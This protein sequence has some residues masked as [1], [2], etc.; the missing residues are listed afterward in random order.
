MTRWGYKV[1]KFDMRYVTD[2]DSEECRELNH[3]GGDGWECIDVKDA[4]D[5]NC[6]FIFRKEKEVDISL[7]ERKFFQGEEEDDR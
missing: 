5:S 3:L 2:E 7:K 4:R 6:W 1:V